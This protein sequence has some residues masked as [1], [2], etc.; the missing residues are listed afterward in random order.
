MRRQDK[1]RNIEQANIM[2]E[3]SYLKRK[4]LLKEDVSNRYPLLP[5]NIKNETREYLLDKLK[6]LQLKVDEPSYLESY[7]DKIMYYY[8]NDGIIYLVDDVD[9]INK[10]QGRPGKSSLLINEDLIIDFEIE[11]GKEYFE[12]DGYHGL[13]GHFGSY[14]RELVGEIVTELY[15]R[16]FDEVGYGFRTPL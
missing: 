6:N 3:N 11:K 12:R 14:F 4:G 16:K 1:R 13:R 10:I 8:G 5:E 2:L 9:S 7:G 15:N